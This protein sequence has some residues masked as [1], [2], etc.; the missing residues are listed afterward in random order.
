LE[1]EAGR[2][3]DDK[4]LDHAYLQAMGRIEV[5]AP[6][7]RELACKV[8]SWITCARRRSSEL[9]HAIAIEAN[10]HELD[11]ENITDIEL[12]VS[13]CAGLVVINESKTIRL[14]HYTT[15]EYFERNWERWFLNAHADITKICATYLS[16]REFETGSSPTEI[17]KKRIRSNVLYDYCARNWRYHARI[18]SIEGGKLLLESTGKVSACSQAMMSR[19][20]WFGGE[21]T[22]DRSTPC[23]I[24]RTLE[25]HVILARKTARKTA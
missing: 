19:R 18:S 22:D 8:L 4:I 14:V 10:Q 21:N 5:Q 25:I 2:S 20:F 23:S 16:F 13:V 7:H 6:E 24:L 11:K 3:N 9:Q 12:L 15:Q 17:H 1:K